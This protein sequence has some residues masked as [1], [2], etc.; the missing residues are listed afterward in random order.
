MGSHAITWNDVAEID[1]AKPE[2]VVIGSGTSGRARLT[3][4]TEVDLREAKLNLEVLP[5]FRAVERFNQLVDEGK[6]VA[7][8]IHITC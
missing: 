7:A 5:S 1:K 4:S 3:V 6:R 2:V 8:L